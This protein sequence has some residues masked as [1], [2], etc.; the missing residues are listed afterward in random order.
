MNTKNLWLRFAALA[1]LVAGS[2]YALNTY[3]LRQGIDLRGGHSLIFEIR[4]NEAE[5]ARLEAQREQLQKE[6]AAAEDEAGKEQLEDRL[7]RIA[8]EI[9]QL[10]RGVESGDLAERMISILKK[11]VDPNGLMALEWTPLGSNRIEIRMPAASSESEDYRGE[12]HA[13]LDS[14]I[15]ANVQRAEVRTV[16]A[17]PAEQRGEMIAS[18]VGEDIA[19]R[20][21]F[22]RLTAAQDELSASETARDE[23]R[24]ALTQARASGAGAEQIDAL[25]RAFSEAL[26]R[27]ENALVAYEDRLGELEQGNISAQRLA[28]VLDYYVSPA[29]E[30]ALDNPKEVSRRRETYQRELDELRAEQS[31][32][33]A[34]IDAVVAAYEKWANVRRH[35]DDPADLKRLIA[36]AGVLEFRV[37][38]YAPGSNDEYALAP[39]ERDSYIETL[40][41]EGPEALRR[42]G[43]RLQWFP[44][45]DEDRGYGSL[46]TAEYAGQEYVL[47]SNQRGYVMLRE[48]G[49]GSW[50]LSRVYPTVDNTNRPAVGFEFDEPGAQRFAGL[51]SANMGRHMAILLD[52]EVYSAPVIRAT[53]SKSGIIEMPTADPGEVGNLIRTLE[54]GSLP[55]RLNPEPVSVSS[56]GP[57]IGAVN[58]ELGIRAAYWGLLCVAIFMLLYYLLAGAIADVA[59]ILNIILVLGAMSLF[60]AVFT[61]PGIAG[62]IL[63][64]GIAV[65]ANVLIFE[66]LR[67][68]Q[69]KGQ[70]IGMAIKNAY[71][72]AFSAIFDANITTLLTCAILG[73]FG[74]EEVRG[75]A[76]TLGLGVLFSM[77]TALLVTR[78]IFQVLLNLRLLKTHVPMLRI[79][80]TPRVNW[81]SKRY[82]FWTI[83]GAFMILG[84]LSMFWQGGNIFG[85][86]FS[87]GTQASLAF[88]DDALI[89]GKLPDDATVRDRF[90]A[91][92]SALGF[93]RLQATAR[94]ETRLDPTKVD[95]FL[96]TY[97]SGGQVTLAEWQGKR[98]DADFFRKVDADGDGVLTREE[99]QK[100]LPPLEFQ[101]STTETQVARIRETAREAFGTALKEQTKHDFHLVTGAPVD[102]LGLTMPADG[103]LRV[104]GE[105]RREINPSYR[106]EL[107]DYDDGVLLVVRDVAPLLSKAEL[108]QRIA[109]MREQPDFA[110]Q[111]VNPTAVLGLTAGEEGT[112]S[113]FAVIVR[114]AEAGN[115]DRAGAWEEFA[116]AELE[117]ITAALEREEAINVRS[118]DP[119][120]AGEAAWRAGFAVVFS[121]LAIVLYLWLRFGNW[122]WGAAAVVCLVHDVIIVVGLVAASAWVQ[123]TPIGAALGIQSFKIDLAMVAA[124]LTVIGYSVND[125]IVVFDRIRENRGKL[126][127]VSPLVI[128]TSI[129]QTLSRT[130]LTSGTTFIVVIIM[131]VMGGTGIHAFNFALLAGILFGTY[132]SVAVASPLLMGFRKALVAKVAGEVATTDA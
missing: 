21:R 127:T 108:V 120:V 81:M 32:R 109:D 115:L 20:E 45:R 113:S 59:L 86:E 128:N 75:F 30:R 52:D 54:A 82:A 22:E 64:I 3:G 40:Q 78:W 88:R 74:T 46:I 16:L 97:G 7:E 13:A 28:T 53:I 121:W 31:V 107:L 100:T 41:S 43:D 38:P 36:K 104:T 17:A 110:D 89:D 25:Q 90:I 101:V 42:R 92:A 117:L 125:T 48:S 129:N 103:R 58:R 66:R 1:L 9:R 56:F 50:S 33:V 119:Q 29:E 35:L 68:E 91:Q 62:I 124:I 77:F 69:A 57:S 73:W 8:G 65:D 116:A 72:R 70:S 2:L 79:I 49:P 67:E 106:E 84:L 44:V 60:S 37:A 111:S 61:L 99:L 80:G 98:M 122:R 27:Y 19:Q 12:Y 85:I 118:F 114:P 95:T 132:S 6:Q 63:T 24:E 126:T 93:D 83:S 51:T 76:I 26:G 14:L 34:Q 131:Y 18:L 5:V 112:F 130:L 87:S 11:R 102:A 94:V 55:A 96:S 4:T 10:R 105:V 123:N 71:E 23:A 39:A 47:L 15:A